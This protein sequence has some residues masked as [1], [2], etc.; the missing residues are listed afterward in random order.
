MSNTIDIFF[1]NWKERAKA[2]PGTIFSTFMIQANDLLK[3]CNLFTFLE[4]ILIIFIVILACFC[5]SPDR[6]YE[7]IVDLEAI[8]LRF[9]DKIVLT[10]LEFF[11]KFLRVVE[12]FFSNL[13]LELRS[14]GYPSYKPRREVVS[15]SLEHETTETRS[16]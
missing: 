14:G 4:R 7:K 2:F 10:P 13:L 11:C 5:F 9:L 3:L 8:A 1:D 15:I 6:F 16:E 12:E